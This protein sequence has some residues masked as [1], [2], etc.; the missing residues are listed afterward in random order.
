MLRSKS[1][2][3]KFYVVNTQNQKRTRVK[4]KDYLTKKQIRSMGGKPDMLWQFAQHLKKEHQK[5]GIDIEVYVKNWTSVNKSKRK[6]LISPQTD[7]TA[8]E[9]N[10]WGHNDWI[11]VN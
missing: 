9:W 3:N 11:I 4:L 7:L 6:P 2:S 1:G 5:K 8:V 10:Y